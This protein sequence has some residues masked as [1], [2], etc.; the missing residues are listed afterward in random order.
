MT[1]PTEQSLTCVSV[2][3]QQVAVRSGISSDRQ[4]AANTIHVISIVHLSAARVKL[5]GMLGY[6]RPCNVQ[7]IVVH[8]SCRALCVD[9]PCRD[10]DESV[11]RVTD[12][13]VPGNRLGRRRLQT[14][15][16]VVWGCRL[17]SHSLYLAAADKHGPAGFYCWVGD[18]YGTRCIYFFFPWVIAA[19][20]GITTLA[21][22]VG[23]D[24]FK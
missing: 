11:P 7:S 19:T 13:S 12:S 3:P 5:F 6:T 22:P 10:G 18:S 20:A 15:P 9:A 23:L 16:G 1:I 24:V 17:S 4:F 2:R 21:I 14:P 8:A